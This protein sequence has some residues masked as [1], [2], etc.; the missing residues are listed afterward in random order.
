VVRKKRFLSSIC[1]TESSKMAYLILV[2]VRK[3]GCDLKLVQKQ[4]VNLPFEKIYTI[5]FLDHF[6][7]RLFPYTNQKK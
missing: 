4:M 2:H 6:I 7:Y 5:S 1:G 3:C